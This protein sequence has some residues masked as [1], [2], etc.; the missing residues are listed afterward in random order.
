MYFNFLNKYIV[1]I[2]TGHYARGQG[3]E[4]HKHNSWSL[5]ELAVEG[6]KVGTGK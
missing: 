1:S 6:R 2:Y 5:K 4:G 3:Q